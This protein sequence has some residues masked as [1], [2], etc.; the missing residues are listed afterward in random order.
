MN[1]IKY[2]DPFDL[3]LTLFFAHRQ[4]KKMS[5][6][7][8]V[9]T[10]ITRKPKIHTAARVTSTVPETQEK[11]DS[12]RCRSMC[13]V[14]LTVLALGLFGLGIYAVMQDDDGI[15]CSVG[16]RVEENDVIIQDGCTVIGGGATRRSRRLFMADIDRSQQEY[17]RRGLV[18]P[19][20]RTFWDTESPAYWVDMTSGIGSDTLPLQAVQ[21]FQTQ[22]EDMDSTTGKQRVYNDPSEIKQGCPLY[23]EIVNATANKVTGI[24]NRNGENIV[25]KIKDKI[26]SSNSTWTPSGRIQR[27]GPSRTTPTLLSTAV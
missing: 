12:P 25:D 27:S 1:N 24:Q 5:S 2:V 21:N 10:E 22:C 15:T 8:F 16:Q 26:Y 7:G 20:V 18:L 13:L 17:I 9:N 14:F 23:F 11:H 19:D 3:C 6:L 4:I